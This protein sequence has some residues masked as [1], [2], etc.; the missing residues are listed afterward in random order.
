MVG[1]GINDCPSLAAA[2]V[3][4]AI[5]PT[6][7][8][9]AVDSAGI[10][11]MS[12]E[13]SRVVYLL[14]LSKFCRTVIYQN[15]G[16]SILIKIVFFSVSLALGALWLAVLSDVIGLLFV[17]MNGVRP[18]YFRTRTMKVTTYSNKDFEVE[19]DPLI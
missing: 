6:A 11:L 13:L 3:G 18:L 17:I 1:D 4:I 7:T 5:G 19:K 8:G 16:G 2:D 15:I 10:T 9:L 12:D 14:H